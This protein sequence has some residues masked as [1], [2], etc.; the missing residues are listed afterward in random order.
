MISKKKMVAAIALGS[1]AMTGSVQ[2]A[3]WTPAEVDA[4]AVRDLQSRLMVAALRC[5]NSEH[6]LLADYNR[7]IRENRPLLRM[8]NQV[9][10]SH[11]AKGNTRK[12]AIKK[13]DRYAVSLANSYGAGSG[14]LSECKSMQILARTAANSNGQQNSLV[15]L[16][17]DYSLNPV[18]PNG[19]CGIV[20]ASRD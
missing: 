17:R 2:A 6:S 15:K 19:R 16:A 4:A 8:G 13:Y 9:L 5:E 18:L 14:D 11:F 10:K 12:Q 20:L 1:V 7:F 3:C